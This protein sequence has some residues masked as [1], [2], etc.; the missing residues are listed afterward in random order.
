MIKNILFDLDGTLI[1]IDQDKFNVEYLSCIGDYFQKYGYDKKLSVKYLFEAIYGVMNNDGRVSNDELFYQYIKNKINI[2]RDLIEKIFNDMIANEYDSLKCCVEKIDLAAK[3][4]KNLKEKNYNLILATN[5]FFPYDAIKKRMAWGNI[6]IND[7]SYVTSIE[8]CNYFKPNINFYKQIIENNNL[9]IEECM[10]VGNDLI[11]DLVIE[12]LG[13]PCY[14]ITDNVLNIE[15][16]DKCKLKGDYNEFY[17][18]I[19]N[20]ERQ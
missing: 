3:V 19:L 9:K 4:I 16:I 8:K 6:D 13:I 17:D 15:N 18:Y 11:E 2:S 14:I 5:A 7:F 12:E 10:M 20:L 1:K